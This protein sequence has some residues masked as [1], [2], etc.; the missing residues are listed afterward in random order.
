MPGLK[1]VVPTFPRDAYGLLRASIEDPNPVVFIE[2]RWLHN[3]AGD[4]APDSLSSEIDRA[5]LCREGSDVTLCASGLFTL[6]AIKAAD[7]LAQHGVS[8]EVIDLRTLN[9]IDWDGILTSVRKTGRLVAV[10]SASLTG[11]V[12]GEIV[13]RTAAEAFTDLLVAPIRIAQPDVPEPTSPRL[14][15]GFHV[16]AR[17]ITETVLTAIGVPVPTEFSSFIDNTPHDVPGSWFAGPF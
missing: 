3:V 15:E 8:C 10:D 1:V 7:W 2:H 13:A 4:L 11:S 17:V 16:T 9:P 6:E 12:S 14:T 5:R